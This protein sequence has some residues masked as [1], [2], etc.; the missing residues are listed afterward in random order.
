MDYDKI[1]AEV[2]KVKGSTFISIDTVTEVK[3][4]GGKKNPLQGRVRKITRG[5]NVMIFS[6]TEQNGYEN[7]VKRRMLE[8]GKDPSTFTL[9]KRAWGTRIGETPFIEHNGKH[10]L[11]CVFISNG[12]S[13]YF[14]DGVET[15]KDEI[16]GIPE[17]K[18]N[19][20]SQG[21]IEN[22]VIIRTFSLDSIAAVR[23]KGVELV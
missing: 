23:M 5:A 11:E 18:E 9:G 4:T 6:G 20:E 15:S 2:D 1:K 10:Y 3:L 8:E 14:V 7:M 12:K 13:A 21:G 22:K 17:V 16:E 19:T